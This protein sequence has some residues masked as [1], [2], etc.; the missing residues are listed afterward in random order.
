MI[1]SSVKVETYVNVI[2][3]RMKLKKLHVVQTQN[4][5]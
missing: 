4:I 5:E 1:A 3:T 2:E